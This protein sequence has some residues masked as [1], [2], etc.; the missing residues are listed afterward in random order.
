M[1]SNRPHAAHKAKEKVHYVNGIWKIF[2]TFANLGARCT[3][4]Y[5]TFSDSFN[6]FFLQV[7]WILH[8][9][10]VLSAGADNLHLPRYLRFFSFR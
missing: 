6:L 10:P 8:L 4:S 9:V 2:K 5:G 3:T 7:K 1:V